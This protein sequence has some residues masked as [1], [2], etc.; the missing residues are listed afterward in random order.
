MVIRLL[1]GASDDP[2]VR[3]ERCKLLA[4]GC[5]L[6][7]IGVLAAAIVAPIFNPALHPGFWTRIGGGASA[8][9]IELLALRIMGYMSVSPSSED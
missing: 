2:V 9:V 8:A 1:I 3:V 4:G 6:I 7:A 5:Q